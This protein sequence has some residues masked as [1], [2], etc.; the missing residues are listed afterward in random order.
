[1]LI[2]NFGGSASVVIDEK[3]IRL[4][5]NSGLIIRPW[6]FHMY[7]DLNEANLSW[8]YVTFE[9]NE[10]S[11][12]KAR[13]GN[14]FTITPEILND[15]YSLTHNFLNK[16][17][18]LIPL[19]TACI[20]AELTKQKKLTPSN[21]GLPQLMQRTVEWIHNHL[22]EPF[23]IED[24][25]KD[26]AISESRLR[27]LFREHVGISLGRHIKLARIHRAKV[28]LQDQHL[29]IKEVAY[30]SGFGSEQSFCRAF[31]QEEDTTPNSFRKRQ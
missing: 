12:L 4:E 7:Q 25:A 22:H 17:E 9:I 31:A 6:Q 5:V 3:I 2:F 23:L 14:I 16:D 18:S 11:P 20:I 26:M 21:T 15:L 10:P 1:M 29:P 8:L 28:L 19:R 24:I 27:T 30:Q 13:G